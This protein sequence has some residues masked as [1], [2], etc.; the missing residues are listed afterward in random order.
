MNSPLN[1]PGSHYPEIRAQRK[2]MDP[3]LQHRERFVSIEHFPNSNGINQR[4]YQLWITPYALDAIQFIPADV[5]LEIL[6]GIAGLS[7]LPRALTHLQNRRETN[8][9]KAP[10]GRYLIHYAIN[11]GLAGTASSKGNDR[12]P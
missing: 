3:R 7:S 10:V 1:K 9:Y 8:I 4:G 12:G 2:N 11:N 6:H 5:R